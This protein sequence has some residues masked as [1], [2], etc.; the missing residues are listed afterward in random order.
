METKLSFWL[1]RILC[2]AHCDGG[3]EWGREGQGWGAWFRLPFPRGQRAEAACLL[4]ARSSLPSSS[5]IFLLGSHVARVGSQ[6]ARAARDFTVLRRDPSA[7]GVRH[8]PQSGTRSRQPRRPVLP[9]RGGSLTR[10]ATVAVN[11]RSSPS[12]HRGR[13]LSFHLCSANQS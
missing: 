3:R 4:T 10:L 2:D 9:S 8:P 12:V 7:P 1:A 13:Y 5:A 11:A 6:T